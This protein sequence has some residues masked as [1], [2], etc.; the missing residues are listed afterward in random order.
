MKKNTRKYSLLV[1]ITVSILFIACS[2]EEWDKHFNNT[3]VVLSDETLTDYI[4]SEPSFSIFYRM[5]QISGYDI[6]LN[7]PQSFTV[8]VPVDSVMS[9]FAYL[10]QTDPK[11]IDTLYITETVAN[12]ITRFT[13]PTS[14]LDSV[15]VYLLSK[16]LVDFQLINSDYYFGKNRLGSTINISAKNGILHTITGY[17]PYVPSLWLHVSRLQNADS[18]YNF[19]QSLIVTDDYGDEYNTIFKEYAQL[20][21]DDSTYTMLL[22]TD[23]AWRIQLANI[24]PYY[25]VFEDRKGKQWDYSKLA[26]IK[27]LFFSK[28]S[29]PTGLDSITST[30]NTTFFDVTNLFSETT[31][32]IASNGLLCVTDSLHISAADSWNK[33]IKIEAENNGYGRIN[34]NNNLYVKNSYGTGYEASGGKYVTL[35]S[36]ATND[37]SKS[38]LNIG[39]PNVLSAK[40]NVYVVFMPDKIEYVLKP[41]PG[42]VSVYMTYRKANGNYNATVFSIVKSKVDISAT[43]VTKLLVGTITFP[44][45]SV[46]D[47]T[48]NSIEAR[49]KV[50]N[51]IYKEKTYR[52]TLRID[53]VILEP[54]I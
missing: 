45:C 36:T 50:E 22:P 41:L 15:R 25:K 51:V 46:Y 8:W 28:V 17:Q 35:E 29:D 39:I 19:F 38:F 3:D 37:I 12:H 16:K 43:D 2:N 48:N 33:K 52:T 1:A 34:E 40:Y 10:K 53:Y 18:I 24:L 9:S 6:I 13:Y 30:K 44:W 27:N 47:G 7:E 32:T 14:G 20:D 31:R 26:L 5:M 54:T 21:N 42:K 4:K 11:L 49:I 23:N